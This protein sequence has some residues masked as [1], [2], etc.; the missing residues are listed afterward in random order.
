M[1]NLISQTENGRVFRCPTCKLIHFEYKNLNFNFTNKEYNFF[2]NYM[3][4][5][6]GDYWEIKNANSYFKRKIFIPAGNNNFN[7]IL[8]KKELIEIKKLLSKSHINPKTPLNIFNC[9]FSNN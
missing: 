4:E 7:I 1:I 5:I 3:L 8:N 9:N 2:V 6:D